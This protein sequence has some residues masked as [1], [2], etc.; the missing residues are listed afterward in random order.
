MPPMPPIG[1]LL[2]ISHTNYRQ[3]S[4]TILSVLAPNLHETRRLDHTRPSRLN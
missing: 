3:T 2:S 1:I 4:K